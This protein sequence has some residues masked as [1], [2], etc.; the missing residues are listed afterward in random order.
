MPSVALRVG[1][2]VRAIPRVYEGKAFENVGEDVAELAAVV[3][4]VIGIAMGSLETFPLLM[5]EFI[6]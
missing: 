4:S 3:G 5:G 6:D 2:A 1:L